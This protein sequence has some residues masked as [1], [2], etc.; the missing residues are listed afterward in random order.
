MTIKCNNTVHI[1][2]VRLYVGQSSYYFCLII[3]NTY[4]AIKAKPFNYKLHVLLLVLARIYI[5]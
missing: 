5:L 2:P 3:D 1:L 4:F